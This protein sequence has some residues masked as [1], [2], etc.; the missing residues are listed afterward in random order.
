MVN[1]LILRYEQKIKNFE[2]E[3]NKVIFDFLKNKKTCTTNEINDYLR[4]KTRNIKFSMEK[5]QQ[6]LYIEQGRFLKIWKRKVSLKKVYLGV[7]LEI[8]NF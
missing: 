7:E 4:G 3:L 1:S 5:L 2:A 6:K 8:Y